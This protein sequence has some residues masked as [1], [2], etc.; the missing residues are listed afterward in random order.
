LRY[1][2]LPARIVIILGQQLSQMRVPFGHA[3]FGSE[4]NALFVTDAA[5][6]S[7]GRPLV[8]RGGF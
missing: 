3:K 6:V 5:R 2:A 8:H 4:N 1:R 7:A